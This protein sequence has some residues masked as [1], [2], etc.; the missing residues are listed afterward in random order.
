MLRIEYA[1]FVSKRISRTT[2]R[3]SRHV[4]IMR[5]RAA[6][7]RDGRSFHVFRVFDHHAQSSA[8]AFAVKT[9]R[10]GSWQIRRASVDVFIADGW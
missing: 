10:L 6:A 4:Q 3:I 5:V 2:R 7:A 8:D 9:L 1:V